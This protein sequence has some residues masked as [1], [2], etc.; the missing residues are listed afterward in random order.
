MYSK[1]HC[2]AR[3][4]QTRPEP[5][6][7]GQTAQP[8]F[9]IFSSKAFARG[10][11]AVLTALVLCAFVYPSV[12]D[13]AFGETP[14]EDT[15]G[16][17]TQCESSEDP[18][19]VAVFE[20]LKKA[21]DFS[22]EL[23]ED[24]IATVICTSTGEKGA[25]LYNLRLF[26]EGTAATEGTSQA[27][28]AAQAAIGKGSK[29]EPEWL[30]SS[31]LDQ[32]GGH[33]HPYISIMQAYS[34]NV[35]M[36]NADPLSEYHTIISPGIWLALPRNKVKLLTIS[37]STLTAGGLSST[38]YKVGFY[39]RIQTY[40]L[41]QADIER[42]YRYTDQ[43][44]ESHT[45]EGLFEYN[46]RGGFTLD[47]V[48]QFRDAQNARGSGS[49]DAIQT[50]KSKLVS[51]LLLYN[52]GK[53][54]SLRADLGKFEID[55]D[56]PQNSF[57]DRTDDSYSG[58]VFYNFS[59]KTSVFVN[60]ELIEVRYHDKTVVSDSDE[61]H[62]FGGLKWDATDKTSGYIKAGSG[63]KEFKNSAV[64][65]AQEFILE[66]GATYNPGLK[67]M[68]RLSAARKTTETNIPTAD[69]IL[70][71]NVSV[72]YR[73][74]FRQRISTL[75]GVSYFNTT[76][77]GYRSSSGDANRQDEYYSVGLDINY[78]FNK[79]LKASIGYKYHHRNSTVSMFNY[80]SNT[81]YVKITGGL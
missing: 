73:Q 10:R 26:E 61:H 57:M 20:S 41:Y 52:P 34:D 64:Q 70:S 8:A 56:E 66:T 33:I 71:E 54:I 78:D 46:L 80:E 28:Q 27:A 62:Y 77:R 6:W 35:F 48:G 75:L 13:T 81:Y 1:K 29:D 14:T 32:R 60:Y 69:Y 40:L 22:L 30:R 79:Y 19:E 49:L 44:T 68:F 16:K 47:L 67:S 50:F 5:T 76:Y 4:E 31:A 11:R 65:D 3:P 36:S 58:H 63:K 38:R 74:R 45:L 15:E 55:Y 72:A 2:H 17:Y 12:A 42:F 7:T 24:S 39:R 53:K 21:E 23:K 59:P 18:N 37:A 43:N 51:A 9:W 25:V